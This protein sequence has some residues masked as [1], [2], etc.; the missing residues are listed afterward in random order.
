MHVY[1]PVL[2]QTAL[3]VKTVFLID[4]SCYIN[5]PIFKEG[6]FTAMCHIPLS[7]EKC[8]AYFL[9]SQTVVKSNFIPAQ[10]NVF[11]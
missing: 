8:N 4:K 1:V 7:G 6:I 11:Y 3:I 2:V 5:S 10:C 9:T